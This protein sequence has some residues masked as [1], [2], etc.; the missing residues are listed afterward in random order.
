VQHLAI[1]SLWAIKGRLDHLISYV[2]N[3]EK[4]KLATSNDKDLQTLWNVLSYTT[5]ADKTEEKL[6]V[7]GINCIP[8]IAVE[9]MI[10]TQKQ[11]DKND[12]RIAFHGFQSFRP[13]EVTPDVAH[14]IGMKLAMEMWGD[15]FQV[16]VST[17]LDK[18][19]L[20]SHFALNSVSFLDGMKYD[21]SNA[22]YARM[23][24]ISDRLCK[25][26]NLSIINNSSK[27]RT[28]RNIYLAEKRGEPTRYNL[29]RRDIELA[30]K[31]SYNTSHF[32]TALEEMGYEFQNTAR[33]VGLK[34]QGA[35]YF[36]RL[37]TLGQ[38]YTVDY[39]KDR[40]FRNNFRE[41]PVAPYE[42]KI[43]RY[44]ISGSA[45]K[46][47][48]IGGL[49]ALYLH[50]CY[51]L[52]I[53]PKGR[54]FK[55]VHPLLRE[56][57]RFLDKIIAQTNLIC[58]NRIENTS[59][60]SDFVNKTKSQIDEYI[61]LRKEIQTILRRKDAP[62]NVNELMQNKDELT[63]QITMLRKQIRT[64][65]AI[66]ERSEKMRHNLNAMKEAEKMKQQKELQRKL[67]QKKSRDYE[68]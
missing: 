4:T 38:N 27:T 45:R 56:D 62:S 55:P 23:R 34:P 30:I 64:A 6:Y 17:H 39:I 15:R 59:Q 10:I 8:A 51:K 63:K 1:T 31:Q 12:G 68:R 26:Y 67:K 20:H 3:P 66:K 16:V 28:P 21:R 35:K 47:K 60:L 54:K 65:A 41:Y 14:E 52:G 40:I 13:N 50:Y 5:R 48:K 11:F 46:F 53:L 32:V 42:R 44:S 37:E 24:K 7:N 19:H 2:E 61:S 22:E 36:T 33:F 9:Q 25:E 49:H 18:D 43:K 58:D 29:M 57:I